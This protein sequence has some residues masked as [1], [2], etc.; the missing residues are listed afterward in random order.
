M[1]MESLLASNDEK[2]NQFFSN[3]TKI[4]L[5]YYTSDDFWS[6]VVICYQQDRRIEELTILLGQYRK[7]REVMALTQGKNDIFFFFTLP[8]IRSYFSG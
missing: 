2:V 5:I 7:M 3:T 1:G 6:H 4:V 8:F